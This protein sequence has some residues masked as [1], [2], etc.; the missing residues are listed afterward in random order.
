MTRGA[1]YKIHFAF[2]LIELKSE[3]EI[4]RNERKNVSEIL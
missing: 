2:L 4:V 1:I 3:I